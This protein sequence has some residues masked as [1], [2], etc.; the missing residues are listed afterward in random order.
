ML[1]FAGTSST[2][3]YQKALGRRPQNLLH[4]HPHP[5]TVYD[6]IVDK[7]TRDAYLTFVNNVNGKLVKAQ[8]RVN[9]TEV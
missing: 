3:N 2:S 7:K 4:L 5:N 6:E 9:C 1:Y 8:V